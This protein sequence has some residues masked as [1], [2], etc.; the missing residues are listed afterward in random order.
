MYRCVL[1]CLVVVT[2]AGPEAFG[3]VGLYAVF[4]FY[5]LSG[6]VV[7]FILHNSYLPMP[8][9]LKKYALN[10]ALRIFPAYWV[11]MLFSL[12][13]LSAFPGEA[14]EVYPLY[15]MPEDIR[16]W[17][18]NITTIGMTDPLTGAFNQTGIIPIAWSLGI[19]LI[20][21]VLMPKFLVNGQAR[22]RFLW[23][24]VGYTALGVSVGIYFHHFA[25]TVQFTNVFAAAL[26]FCT[27]LLL[28]TRKLNHRFIVPPAIGIIAIPALMLV[29]ALTPF[30]YTDPYTLG[31]G[32]AFII[33]VILV[34]Y[35]SQ[36]PQQ[37]LPAWV[38][39][40]D[41]FLGNLAYPIYLVHIPAALVVHVLFPEFGL[42]N[43][44]LLAATLGV[45]FVLAWGLHC[46]VEVPMDGVRRRVKV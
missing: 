26:P 21:W 9:G 24:S 44:T 23:F 42:R 27:G 11:A 28:F 7:S 6:Y 3:R 20:Y 12:L 31:F 14:L 5:I 2:H 13:L 33:N 10:R 8:E 18:W 41:G 30:V 46:L 22:R 19:E 32:G 25:Q 1:A 34:A 39:K 36:I 4:A 45:S 17:L 38:R 16:D 15:K 40:I 37:C 35:L 43:G 29:V